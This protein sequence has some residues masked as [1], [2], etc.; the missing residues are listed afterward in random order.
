MNDRHSGRGGFTLIE[1]LLVLALSVVLMALALP[2]LRTAW[3]QSKLA[4][5]ADGT[6]ALIR[7]AR[8]DAIKNSAQSVVRIV[9]PTPTSQGRVEAFSDRNSDNAL[10]PD[11]PE[12]GHVDLPAGVYFL[13][14]P[15]LA[16]ED[17]VEGFTE[18]PPGPNIVVF[19]PAGSIDESGAFRFGD[20]YGNFLE[21]RVEP[22]ATATV[23]KLKA[24]EEGGT[25]VFYEQ[26]ISGKP[27]VWN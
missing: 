14:P 5:V 27:W 21:I 16:D 2:A 12:L 18:D 7:Q 22:E 13:A 10:D 11:E 19:Q 25:W 3:H 24:V 4:G 23:S 8:M 6:R 20:Q 17:S 26:G 9:L 15:D 1:M